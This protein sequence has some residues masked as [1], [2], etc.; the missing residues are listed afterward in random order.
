MILSLPALVTGF[1]TGIA[2][3]SATLP[4][5]AVQRLSLANRNVK[6]APAVDAA[7][8]W[9]KDF[10][11]TETADFTL[12]IN[13]FPLVQFNGAVQRNATGQVLTFTALA[14]V[15]VRAEILENGA[16][17]TGSVSVATSALMGSTTYGLNLYGEGVF[18]IGDGE[19]VAS[20]TSASQ[21]LLTCTGMKNRRLSVVLV[22]IESAEGL[23][24]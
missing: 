11:A 23:Y 5:D 12:N 21:L 20:V 7:F 8:V 13:S 15:F 1:S 16:E 2:P 6:F 10:P 19:N 9:T 17:Y 14:L 24:S 18:L 22:G 3:D 4:V